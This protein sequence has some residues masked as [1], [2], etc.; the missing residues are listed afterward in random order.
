MDT[1]I[2]CIFILEEG[3]NHGEECEPKIEAFIF[4]K[5]LLENTDDDHTMSI[6]KMIEALRQYDINAERKSV[7]D[8]LEALRRYGLDIVMHKSRTTT[9]FVANC[10]FALAELKLFGR[11]SAVLPLYYLQEEQ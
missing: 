7:Y 10:S 4:A 5:I 8:D 11:C 6:N 3:V 9:Y 2:K 1:G